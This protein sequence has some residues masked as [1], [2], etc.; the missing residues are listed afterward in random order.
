MG[1]A[2]C[3]AGELNDRQ[4]N[5]LRRQLDKD[6][7]ATEAP[8]ET[9]SAEESERTTGAPTETSSE[10]A[11]ASSD[12]ATQ[13][14]SSDVVSS[15]VS[16]SAASSDAQ[17]SSGAPATPIP[18]CA[19]QV[20][21]TTCAG[22]ACHY[23]GAFNF[24]P[25]FETTEDVFTMLTTTETAACDDAVSPLYIDLANPQNS[26]LLAKVKAQQPSGCGTPMPSDRTTITQE[27]ITCLED[28]IGSL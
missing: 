16:S 13:E 18:D 3:T 7:P 11:A 22:S 20:F 27:E 17:T 12:S 26:Y 25:N 1:A 21:H 10:P 4:E 24:P 19:I 23:Q 9:T 5:Y 8:A 15:Q 6:Y 28:W 14:S 2:G